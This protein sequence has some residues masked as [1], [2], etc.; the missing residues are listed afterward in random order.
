MNDIVN[1]NLFL[2]TEVLHYEKENFSYT[3][4]K[5][6]NLYN[7][8]QGISFLRCDFRG[9]KFI[10]SNFYHN[11][12]DRSDF[13]TC[14]FLD[15]RFE[16]VDIGAC[17]MKN[18][19]F[20]NVSFL[21]KN[22][23]NNTSIQE[24]TFENCKFESEKFLVN[25]KKCT[26]KNCEF[27]NCGF[28]R[29]TTEQLTFDNC[30]IYECDLATMHAEKHIFKNCLL[31]EVLMDI[32]Y[33][34]GYLFYNTNI[35]GM[36]VLYRG[37]RVYLENQDTF[38]KHIESLWKE[39]R[40]YEFINANIIYHHYE[41]IPQI[42][43]KSLK[44]SENKSPSIRLLDI[45]DILDSI[46]FYIENCLLP[47]P[48]FLEVVSV[49]E[50]HSWSN[51]PINENIIYRTKCEKIKILLKNAV[52]SDEFIRSAQGNIS[53]ITFRCKT[54]DFETA[55]QLSANI[56]HKICIACGLKDEFS[57]IAK[58]KG[59][60]ILTFA[61]ASSIALVVP[62][63]LK[64]YSDTYFEIKTKK[65]FSKAISQKLKNSS[66]SIEELKT[67][68]EIA[69]SAQLVPNADV[70][71]KKIDVPNLFDSVKIGL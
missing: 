68:N 20:N 59:S 5:D 66:L 27:I 6:Q 30:K 19:Y 15:V 50:H 17:E 9:S 44:L 67:L 64:C 53:T 56:L 2:K 21:E 49:L 52:F 46:T 31:Q 10:H 40:Y 1:L 37:D 39:Q 48:I 62:K 45:S 28:E 63:L 70:N 12:L 3:L 41:M 26:F 14:I 23:Y 57:L 60:W 55:Y 42:L 16:N 43:L 33:I 13:I 24:C 34:F 18:C 58:E 36:S 4:F 22:Y 61:I 7:G 11:N 8:N 32:G 47:Y 25:M 71:Y 51:F 54:N 29:S 38:S 35:D 69:A 65:Q